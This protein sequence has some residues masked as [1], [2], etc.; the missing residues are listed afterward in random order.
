MSSAATSST[1]ART[2]VGDAATQNYPDGTLDLP[3]RRPLL[4]AGF[5]ARTVLASQKA[6]V[7]SRVCEQRPQS[8]LESL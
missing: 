7:A 5:P 2:V 4:R 8:L 6:L 3:L 1:A